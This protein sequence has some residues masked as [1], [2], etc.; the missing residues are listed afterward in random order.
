MDEV[1]EGDESDCLPDALDGVR[2]WAFVQEMPGMLLGSVTGVMSFHGV[3]S[4]FSLT[5]RTK[6]SSESLMFVCFCESESDLM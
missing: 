3:L 4:Y 2:A 5:L 6:P 1:D